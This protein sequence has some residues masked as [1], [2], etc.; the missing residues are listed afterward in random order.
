MAKVKVRKRKEMQVAYIEHVGPYDKIPW[1]TYM[2]KLY[3]WAKQHDVRPGFKALGI[4]YDSPEQT[5]PEECRSEIA[6]PVKWRAESDDEVGVQTIPAGDVVETTFHGPS[7]LLAGAYRDI[8]TWVTENGYAWDG[9]AVEVYTRKPKIAGGK[10]I[11]HM[12]LQ[13]P[14]KKRE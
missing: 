5:P 13:I 6:I 12:N 4:Y 1:E 8:E 11:L 14:V 7:D 9:P 10:T 3:A 2:E